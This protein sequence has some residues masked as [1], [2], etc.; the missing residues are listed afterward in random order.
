MCEAEYAHIFRFPSEE[1][2]QLKL[3]VLVQDTRAC[4]TCVSL[5]DVRAKAGVG[6]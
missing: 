5:F 3:G 2:Y 4:P 1:L 6:M